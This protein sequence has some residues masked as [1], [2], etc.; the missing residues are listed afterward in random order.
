M[1]EILPFGDE[2]I[3]INFEQQIEIQINQQV[4]FLFEKINS[5]SIEGITFCIPAYCSL[6]IGYN[7]K[8]I[9]FPYLKEKVLAIFSNS[10]FEFLQKEKR[11]ITIPVCYD[12][13]FALDA[14]EVCSQTS[15]SFQEVVEIH[16]R[17][18]YQVFMMGFL[19]GFGYLGK[20]SE[21]L[22]CTRKSNPRKKVETGSVALAGLQ[23]GIYP[24]DAP[25]GWQIIGKTPVPLFLPNE[26]QPFLFQTGDQV[27][28]QSV[29]KEEFFQIK[30]E[31]ESGN[32][33]RDKWY[34]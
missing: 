34:E 33:N 12:L 6:T 25:G 13:D 32:F 27:R 7:P 14:E 24:T 29:S 16:S 31:V 22:K 17:D 2:A 4:H 20:L 9:S 10:D 26:E 11:K 1:I 8:M 15:L 5:H 23:T 21:Q 30:K 28:F 3:L 19:P 18:W